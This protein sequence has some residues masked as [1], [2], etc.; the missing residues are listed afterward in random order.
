MNNLYINWVTETSLEIK[1][2]QHL[3]HK[4]D[5]ILCPIS[6]LSTF[7]WKIILRHHLTNCLRNSKM[8]LLK[9]LIG[10]MALRY[11]S[12]QYFES[13]DLQHN[14]SLVFLVYC[15]FNSILNFWHNLLQDACIFFQKG[16]DNFE[17]A[18]KNAHFWF[19]CRS[20]LKDL[21]LI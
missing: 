2:E 10:Q 11:W 14:N 3:K 6:K 21:G 17:I 12:E 1:E 8:Q 4:I 16:V 18:Q 9:I 7:V 5:S 13:F 20:P 15:N 19:G